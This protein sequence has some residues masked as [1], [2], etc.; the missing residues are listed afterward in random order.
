MAKRSLDSSHSE[1]V[2]EALAEA[3]RFIASRCWKLFDLVPQA[4]ME[5]IAALQISEV[6]AGGWQP[7]RGALWPYCRISVWGEIVEAVR[8]RRRFD[9]LCSSPLL[10]EDVPDP[11]DLDLAIDARRELERRLPPPVQSRPGGWTTAEL[12]EAAGMS[13]RGLRYL[14][15][16][17]E[18]YATRVD[19]QLRI[20]DAMAVEFIER[21]RQ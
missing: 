18:L 1:A 7:N 19:G 17:G 8:E 2:V 15:A 9:N 5:G 13:A 16:R 3:R 12:A 6:A 4:E 21:R 10:A 20:P 11:P 14:V